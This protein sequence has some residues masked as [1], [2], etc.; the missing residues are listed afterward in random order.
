MQSNIFWIYV[1]LVSVFG[2]T[3]NSIPLKY[4][5]SIK[6]NNWIRHVYLMHIHFVPESY[7]QGNC[8]IDILLQKWNEQSCGSEWSYHWMT[9]ESMNLDLSS[10]IIKSHGGRGPHYLW[11]VVSH[12]LFAKGL[13]LLPRGCEMFLVVNMTLFI[14]TS[15]L[16]WR[17]WFVSVRHL[18][19]TVAHW[20][21]WHDCYIF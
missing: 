14:N 6:I 1:F 13:I 11:Y 7:F 21:T 15:N 8:I 18:W 16:F 17:E 12:T 20:V 4:R 19:F 10:H 9:I 2:I 3:P 5:Y